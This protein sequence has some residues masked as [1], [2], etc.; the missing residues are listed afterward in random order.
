VNVKADE[1]LHKQTMLSC[2]FVAVSSLY[3]VTDSRAAVHAI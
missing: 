1:A 2:G 3:Q